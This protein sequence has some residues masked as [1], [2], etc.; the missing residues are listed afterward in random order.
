MDMSEVPGLPRSIEDLIPKPEIVTHWSALV[1]NFNMAP[2]EFYALLEQAI[3][4][5][6]I[7]ECKVGYV[8]WKERGI[9]SA[10]RLYIRLVRDRYYYDCCAAPFGTGYFFSSW[11]C[12]YPRH[13]TLLNFIGMA[14]T[15]LG[16]PYL[17]YHTLGFFMGL[18]VLALTIFVLSRLLRRGL[19]QTQ[20][21][22]EQLI[23]GM[24]IFCAL[25]DVFFRRLTYYEMD[26]ATM[27]QS[28]AHKALLAVI[29][30][31]TKGKVLRPLTEE[32]RRPIMR[33]FFG[34]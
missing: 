24:T 28:A 10:Q 22:L 33:E 16:L 13:L 25:Y 7:P 29:D 4:L 18:I 15:I 5:R 3:Q 26:T 34:K 30:E 11:L 31:V 6:Q 23:S 19:F 2:Q 12:M 27:F 14:I 21:Q 17:F 9:L 20:Q 1:E 8:A 32:E